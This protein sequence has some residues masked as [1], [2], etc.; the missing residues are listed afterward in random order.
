M[1]SRSGT[2]GSLEDESQRILI[3]AK[4]CS[5][6]GNVLAFSVA[7]PAST[8]LSILCLGAHSD[9]IEIGCGGTMLCLLE[10]LPSVHV[11][12]IVFSSTAVRKQEAIRSANL[13]LKGAKSR[14]ITVHSYRD[15]FFPYV[16]MRIKQ[17]FERLKMRLAPDIVFTHYRHD[18]HQDHRVLNELTWN[19]FRN[20]MILE[21]E[22]PK[23]DGDLGTPN[24]FVPLS[25]QT[26][27]KKAEYLDSVFQT[28]R[29]KHW[30][31]GG[32]FEALMRL[33]GVEARSSTGFAEAFY[34]RK[35]SLHF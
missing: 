32:T 31:S 30:F 20:H 10:S 35:V 8:R 17:E 33:R 26:R 19:T 22:I 25:E 14:K 9:D 1:R 2:L 23:F 24:L 11:D 28:Q 18:L 34:A 4:E 13:F 3:R 5:I 6:E 12:W 7:R 27:K 21:Y 15:G 29:E 16:G